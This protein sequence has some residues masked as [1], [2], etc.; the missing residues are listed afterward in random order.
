MRVALWAIDPE[1]G[2]EVDAAITMKLKQRTRK[3]LGGFPGRTREI[4]KRLYISLADYLK[5]KGRRSKGDVKSGMRV[6]LG[7]SSWNQW[8]EEHGGEGVA[9]LAGVK[10]GKLDCYLDG[11]RYR[12]CR[13][14]AELA[15]ELGQRESLVESLQVGKPDSSDDERFRRRVEYWNHLALGFLPEIYALRGAIDSI[16]QRYF[17]RQQTLFPTVAEGFDNLLALVEKTVGIHNE[18]LAEEIER[19]EK[20]LIEKGYG[21]DESPLTIGLAD[22]AELI[23]RLATSQIA[24]LV[25][26]AKADALDMLGENQKAFQVVE[27]YV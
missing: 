2:I 4:D 9:T 26:M 19:L 16:N 6:G 3:H 10:V 27:R 18:H 1:D 17:D 20:L 11:Y 7:V 14:A 23:A 15:A 12:V 8:I 5:W 24:Y 22:L 25:D 13:D 21:Q